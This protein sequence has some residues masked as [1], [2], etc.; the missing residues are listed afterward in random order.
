MF[1]IRKEIA[2]W[3]GIMRDHAIFQYNSLSPKESKYVSRAQYFME[4]F[5]NLQDEAS[6]FP[7]KVPSAELT[8]L[9]WKNMVALTNFIE[10]KRHM[11]AQL[12]KC[13]LTMDM[14]PTF[15]NHMINEALEYYRVLC[16]TQDTIPHNRVLENLRL[17]KIWLPDASGHASFI[18]ASFDPVEA[19]LIKKSK[20]FV[21]IFD[22]L[23]KKAIKMYMIYER[24][25]LEDGALT[26]FNC[27]VEQAIKDFVAFLEMVESLRKECKV[28]GTIMPLEPNH[29]IR[30][31]IYY[32][33]RTQ[34]L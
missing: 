33:Y 23:H 3:T 7:A 34:N 28:L 14:P 10:F 6:R 9:V 8:N 19:D 18:G 27:Q 25:C 2:F 17:H 30:E 13:E 16:M 31:E 15:L 22:N 32:L 4:I 29:M 1:D 24:T 21:E 26:Y 11:L 5:K 12:M 20:R